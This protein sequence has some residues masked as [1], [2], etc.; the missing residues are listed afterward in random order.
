MLRQL[1][2]WRS[3]LVA[4]L[5]IAFMAVASP[6][7]AQSSQ[8][9]LP[10]FSPSRHVYVDPQLSNNRQAPVNFTGLEARLLQEGQK[11]GLQVFVVATE[12]GSD[13]LNATIPSRDALDKL[14][15]KWQ[16]RPG[17]PSDNYLIIMWVRRADNPNK[18]SVAANGGN[19][20]SDWNM[21]ASYFTDTQDGPLV[22]NLR[23]FMPQ[24]P[25]GAFD[26][27]VVSVN[28]DIDAIKARQ[29][30]TAKEAAF[31]QALPYYIGGGALAALL[32]GTMI[33]LLVRNS[34]RKKK[35]AAL[36]AEWTTKLDSANEL[37]LKLR[38]SY[39]GFLTE[40]S[41]WKSKFKNRTLTTYTAACK[42]FAAFSARRKVA[43]DTLDAARK[44]FASNSFPSVKG[45]AEVEQLLASRTIEVTGEDLPLEEATLF[46]GL[47]EKADYKPGELLDAMS[48]LFEKTNKALAAIVSAFNGAKQNKLDVE[49]L[50]TQVIAQRA[51]IAAAELT[52]APYEATVRELKEG[53]GAFIAILVC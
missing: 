22:P 24:D 31:Q 47:V 19:L 46:G 35:M 17:F 33:F 45:F 40:Q 50:D 20:F 34:S 23:R 16:A 32:F 14:I 52:M 2:Q 41:D 6:A 21:T 51:D 7:L 13:L 18:G 53:Q 11:H 1:S 38:S 9:W 42:D 49:A 39:M 27:V 3:V 29:A 15:L 25:A 44:A 12:G 36:I 28:S 48:T 8:T 30:A 43:T 10:D 4:A 37:Y 26:A 5:L